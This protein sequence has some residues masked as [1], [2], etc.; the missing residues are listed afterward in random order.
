[1]LLEDFVMKEIE[2]NVHCPHEN[3]YINTNAFQ[4]EWV[5]TGAGSEAETGMAKIGAGSGAETGVA[6][7]GMAEA[8]ARSGAE[9]GMI[10]SGAGSG[11]E[12]GMVETGAGVQYVVF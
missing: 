6:E 11:A 1:M 8:G 2:R 10:E 12:T 3:L 4:I 5:A 7:A 9:T